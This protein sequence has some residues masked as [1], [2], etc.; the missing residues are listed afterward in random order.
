MDFVYYHVDGFGGDVMNYFL[1][2]MYKVGDLTSY[3][4]F[5]IMFLSIFTIAMI[6]MTY[7]VIKGKSTF[8]E[9]ISVLFYKNYKNNLFVR[10]VITLLLYSLLLSPIPIVFVTPVVS[11]NIQEQKVDFLG[12]TIN[13]AKSYVSED[14]EKLYHVP[15]PVAV[16]LKYTEKFFYGLPDFQRQGLK[17]QKDEDFSNEFDLDNNKMIF[18]FRKATLSRDSDFM[19]SKCVSDY[20]KSKGYILADE[21]LS[22]YQNTTKKFLETGVA[23]DS[24]NHCYLPAIRTSFVSYFHEPAGTVFEDYFAPI[25]KYAAITQTN[26]MILQS[27]NVKAKEN[28]YLSLSNEKLNDYKN[29]IPDENKILDVM[30]LKLNKQLVNLRNKVNENS[31]KI[32]AISQMFQSKSNVNDLMF[33]LYKKMVLEPKTKFIFNNDINNIDDYKKFLED[34]NGFYEEKLFP[35]Y[36][37]EIDLNELV[38]SDISN[39]SETFSNN[40]IYNLS[41][42]INKDG[43]LELYKYSAGNFTNNQDI[44][45]T[46]YN[47]FLKIT[48]GEILSKY[49]KTIEDNLITKDNL[50]NNTKYLN[51]SKFKELIKDIV[52]DRPEYKQSIEEGIDSFYNGDSFSAKKLESPLKYF[53]ITDLYLEHLSEISKNIEDF[54]KTYLN[55][56][57]MYLV[58]KGNSYVLEIEEN[59]IS[60]TKDEYLTTIVENIRHNLRNGIVF[61]GYVLDDFSDLTKTEEDGKVKWELDKS[62]IDGK[63]VVVSH[64]NEQL[65]VLLENEDNLFAFLDVYDDKENTYIKPIGE[66]N[67]DYYTIG[68]FNKLFEDYNNVDEMVSVLEKVNNPTTEKIKYQILGDKYFVKGV[69]KFDTTSVKCY[70]DEEFCNLLQQEVESL[71]KEDVKEE[72]VNYNYYSWINFYYSVSFNDF[73]NDETYKDNNEVKSQIENYLKTKHVL[74]G[75]LLNSSKSNYYKKYLMFNLLKYG[76]DMLEV[77]DGELTLIQDIKMNVIEKIEKDLGP[78]SNDGLASIA[79]QKIVNSYKYFMNDKTDDEIEKQA[80]EELQEM[81][82]IQRQ[83]EDGSLKLND[84]M[85]MIIEYIA[86]QTFLK[87]RVNFVKIEN[88]SDLLNQQILM[89]GDVKY[90]RIMDSSLV[91]LTVEMII[92]P[93]ADFIQQYQNVV[94]SEVL[95]DFSASNYSVRPE[96]VLG[97]NSAYLTLNDNINK[98]VSKSETEEQEISIV[99]FVKDTF[100]NTEDWTSLVVDTITNIVV[101]ITLILVF[102]I[103]LIILLLTVIAQYIGY[104]MVFILFGLFVITKIVF[105]PF[106]DIKAE[107]AIL[108][109]SSF[110][111]TLFKYMTVWIVVFFVLISLVY[112]MDNVVSVW[113]SNAQIY[114]LK[115]FIINGIDNYSNMLFLIVAVL[116]PLVISFFTIFYSLKWLYKYLKNLTLDNSKIVLHK[117]KETIHQVSS[118]S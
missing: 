114:V 5:G 97:A 83:L 36:N 85:N 44:F 20:D 32:Y 65:Y 8:D 22:S 104:L 116:F 100:N 55:P 74:R 14:S 30:S 80:L 92:N 58:K 1:S 3:Q 45:S 107:P 90:E 48:N 84:E 88:N 67:L 66:Y 79:W 26:N 21:T 113:I 94:V 15:L 71:V 59:R 78:S 81:K 111:V 27:S 25:K 2:F 93:V 11:A 12:W 53:Y 38:E 77:K 106:K 49:Q 7:R 101:A 54:E 82:N 73:L 50:E 75:M 37:K 40:E 60:S 57:G 31:S 18:F 112:F 28:L 41:Y 102:S 63:T 118:I 86:K 16:L 33:I 47:N 51:S 62:T 42:K 95:T 70:K 52:K 96:Y 105:Q 108:Q 23:T 19:I 61:E 98:D 35:S 39:I 13:D 109:D 64:N 68:D 103:L 91:N 110:Y 6:W 46:T 4:S 17:F 115:Y 72:K 76:Q 29:Y 69:E 117:M 56:Y 99:D 89:N 10:F 34:R 24:A 43:Y 9:A 87:D